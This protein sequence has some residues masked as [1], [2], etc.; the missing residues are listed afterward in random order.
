[1]TYPNHNVFIGLGSNLGD[2]RQ[3][4]LEVMNAIEGSG[5]GPLLRSSLW[6]SRPL[7]CPPGSADFINAV[8]GY[9]PSVGETPRGLLEYLQALEVEFGRPQK[10]SVNAPRPIDLDIICFANEAVSEADLVVPHPRAR[11]RL[12][13]LGPLAEIAPM[14]RFPPGD[15][16]IGELISHLK[17]QQA[18][19]LEP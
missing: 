19:R 4:V 5:R 13:V 8:V 11:Q 3:I 12:F 10:R 2:S 1:M 16:S 15:R 17:G 7:D 6:R 9:R 14:L 18:C